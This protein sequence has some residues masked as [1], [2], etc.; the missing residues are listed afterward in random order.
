[1]LNILQNISSTE[2]ILIFLIF[3]ILFGGKTAIKLGRLFGETFREIK[4]VKKSFVDTTDDDKTHK[5]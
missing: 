1:M 3:T 2:L 5:K 4:K